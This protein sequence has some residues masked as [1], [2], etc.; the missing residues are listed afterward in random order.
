MAGAE[1]DAVLGF[2]NADPAGR[3]GFSVRKAPDG[4][5]ARDRSSESDSACPTMRQIGPRSAYLCA[6]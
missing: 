4:T 1:Q 6:I 5:V 2:D 3:A